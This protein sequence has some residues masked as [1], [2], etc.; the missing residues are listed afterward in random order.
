MI[1]LLLLSWLD[2]K[3][4]FISDFIF[5]IVSTFTKLK[6]VSIFEGCEA[7]LILSNVS[8]CSAVHP[9]IV[10]A[11]SSLWDELKPLV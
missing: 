10:F 1:L 7:A 9:G 6:I 2:V 3:F 8:K 4:D 5:P 11:F